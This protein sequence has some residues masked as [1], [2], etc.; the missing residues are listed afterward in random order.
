MGHTKTPKG[1]ISI[2]NSRGRIRLRWRYNGDRYSLNLPY[3]CLPQNMHHATVKVAEIKLDILKGC[4]DPTLKRYAKEHREKPPNDRVIETL[5]V[6][7]K[8]KTTLLLNDLIERFNFW[9]NNIR[10]VDIET[11]I[12]YLYVRKLLEKWKDVPIEKTAEKLNEEKWAVT[13]YNRRLNYLRNFF[14]WLLNSGIIEINPLRDVCRKRDKGKRKNPRRKPLT[15]AEILK[16]LEAIKNDTYC[17]KSSRFK[18]SYYHP[19][20]LFMFLTGVRNG[21]AIGLRVKHID[22]SLKQIEISEAFAR[23]LKGTNHAS[24]IRKGTKMENVRYL[25]VTL[26]LEELLAP[27]IANKSQEDFVFLSQTGLSIDDR[28]LERRVFKPVM[29]SLGYGDKDLYSARHSF[30]TRAAQQKLPI[31]DIAYLMGHST[32]E[33]TI[34]NY[35]SV[36]KSLSNL[37]TLNK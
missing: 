30:G 21:E 10:N 27:L 6:R 16:F 35:I 23:T 20:L 29:K 28:M 14:T 18:H 24:R 8:P 2:Q 9:C 19:F 31:T 26:E 5:N 36:E 15:D 34:R 12:D 33:T 25:P 11:S 17:P 32:V 22:F 3:A 37:P 1:E 7:I 4:F 13:T